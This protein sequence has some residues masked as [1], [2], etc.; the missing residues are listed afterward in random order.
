[1]IKNVYFNDIASHDDWNLTFITR[2][3]PLPEVKEQKVDIPYADGFIDYSEAVSGKVAYDKKPI[4]MEFYVFAD[5]LDWHQIKSDI[6]A[7]IHGQNIRIVFDDDVE[8]FYYGR[9][10]VSDIKYI[11]RGV[12]KL[13]ITADCQPFKYRVVGTAD[14]WIWDIFNFETGIINE[15]IDVEIDGETDVTVYGY[16]RSFGLLTITSTTAMRLTYDG[17]DYSI[18][19]GNNMM[20]DILLAEGENTLTF[21][22]SGKVTIDYRGGVL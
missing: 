16:D 4:S 20:F 9:V 5:Y 13:E 17:D 14:R 22:G 21:T 18:V 11:Q 10:L 3:L 6:A 19:A 2:S 8:Y 7:R 1:M 12:G 15:L